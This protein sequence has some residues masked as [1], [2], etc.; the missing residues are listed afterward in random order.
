MLSG[1][2]QGSVLGPVLFVAYINDLPDGIKS[3]ILMYADDTKI[4]RQMNNED[5]RQELQRD[6][7]RLSRWSEKW[8]LRFN[9]EK[10]NVMHDRN[11]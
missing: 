8:Q 9:V 10:C 11:T 7:D 2:P 6:L 3:F 1:V 5:D 4:F